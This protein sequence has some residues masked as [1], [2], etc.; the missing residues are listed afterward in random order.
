M[1]RLLAFFAAAALAGSA[2]AQ[3]W[4]NAPEYDVLLTSYDIVPGTIRLKAGEPVRL[5]FVNNSNQ[6]HD[7]SARAF[8][9][10][11]QLRRRDSK[12]VVGGRIE[13]P[14]LATE[15]IVLIPRAGRY[16]VSSSNY[17]HR[18]LGMTGRIVVE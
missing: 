11:S 18:M 14:P 6:R 12:L 7:F 3:E 5:R 10:A 4:R 2:Y 13:V 17:L 8:F 9:R 1:R 15:T 16:R